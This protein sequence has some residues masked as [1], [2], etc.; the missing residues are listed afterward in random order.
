M[1]Q[2]FSPAFSATAV[3]SALR[4]TVVE[5]FTAETAETAEHADFPMMAESATAAAKWRQELTLPD[6]SRQ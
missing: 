2:G 6:S 5:R 3:V 1:A 4:R